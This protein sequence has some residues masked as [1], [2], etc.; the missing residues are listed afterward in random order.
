MFNGPERM[1]KAKMRSVHDNETTGGGT[2]HE[3]QHFQSNLISQK[4]LT[5]IALLYAFKYSF[6]I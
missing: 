2:K 3:N 6:N 1:N 5:D 4:V